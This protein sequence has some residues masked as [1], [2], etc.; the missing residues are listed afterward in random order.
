VW[1]LR[2]PDGNVATELKETPAGV[3]VA[4]QRAYDPYGSPDDGGSSELVNKEKSTLGYQ[5]AQTD[6]DSG[7]ILLGPRIYDPTTD[8]FT[9]ADSFVSGGADMALG[10]DP[11]TGNRYVFAAANPV[12]YYENGY[13]PL[14]ECGC[15]GGG[16]PN[17][18]T[19]AHSGNVTPV[20]KNSLV[21]S[22]AKHF[23]VPL[24]VVAG[25]L[26]AER[27]HDWPTGG[28]LWAEENVV[29]QLCS[30]PL[31]N[32]AA[33]LERSVGIAQMQIRRALAVDHLVQIFLIRKATSSPEDVDHLMQTWD[34]DPSSIR[35]RLG[36][37]TWSGVYVAA[38][39]GT[40]RNLSPPGMSW[41]EIYQTDTPGLGA[42]N[43][44]SV[45]VEQFESSRTHYGY[46]DS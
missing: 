35:A 2:D 38:F 9:T 18:E 44:R 30:S 20:V 8:R 10:T 37:S 16:N 43:S 6:E 3:V 4:A 7:N 31:R 26:E 23:G 45:M 25:V 41:E 22:A 28:K 39:M 21:T 33:C 15:S 40:K 46:L 17:D 13:M 24:S 14:Y 34:N 11:L 29:P 12:A 36:N 19:G 42:Y 27:A 32:T 1:L 5:A